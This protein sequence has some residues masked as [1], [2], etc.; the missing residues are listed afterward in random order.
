MEK[1]MINTLKMRNMSYREAKAIYNTTCDPQ[2]QYSSHFFCVT[3]KYI[4]EITKSSEAEF[5]RCPGF[6]SVTPKDFVYGKNRLAD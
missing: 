4:Q 5:L 1:R 3:E 6:S 2:I